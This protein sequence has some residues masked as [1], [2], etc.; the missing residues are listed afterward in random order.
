MKGE[1]VAVLCLTFGL[2]VL[3]VAGVCIVVNVVASLHA[4]ALARARAAVE[5]SIVN[6]QSS[7]PFP[8]R[9]LCVVSAILGAVVGVLQAHSGPAEGAVVF[10][11]TAGSWFV[12][13]AFAVWV[14][15]YLFRGV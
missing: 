14:Y 2:F 8:W 7:M 15:R 4:R 13:L 10:V 11:T 1:D 9:R 12:L 3:A 6:R 5:S